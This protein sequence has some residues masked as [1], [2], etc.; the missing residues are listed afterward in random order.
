MNAS[1]VDRSNLSAR[2]EHGDR[3]SADFKCRALAIWQ[4]FY[5]ADE[6]FFHARN[7]DMLSERL[8][9]PVTFILAN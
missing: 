3:S 2:T 6:V 5:I 9:E 7:P 4:V 8:C 1:V